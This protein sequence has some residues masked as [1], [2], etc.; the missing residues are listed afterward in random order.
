M[1][2]LPTVVLYTSSPQGI[3]ENVRNTLHSIYHVLSFV[4]CQEQDIYKAPCTLFCSSL[5]GAF[6]WKNVCLTSLR[7]FAFIR[8]AKGNPVLSKSLRMVGGVAFVKTQFIFFQTKIIP[9]LFATNEVR[10]Q[11]QSVVHETPLLF[12][13]LRWFQQTSIRYAVRLNGNSENNTNSFME[14]NFECFKFFSL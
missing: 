8:L 11:G 5:K 13:S 14:A 3:S 1:C 2:P 12:P 9:R 10:Y 6:C 4:W 7:S